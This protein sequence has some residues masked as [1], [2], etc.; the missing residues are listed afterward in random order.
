LDQGAMNVGGRMEIGT[1]NINSTSC[2]MRYS[3]AM[4]T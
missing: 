1:I 2:L 4:L 3:D